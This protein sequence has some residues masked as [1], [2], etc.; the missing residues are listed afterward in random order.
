MIIIV[1][2]FEKRPFLSSR[3]SLHIQHVFRAVLRTFA[4][5]RDVT[6]RHFTIWLFYSFEP[7]AV[8]LK[9]ALPV[10]LLHDEICV[11]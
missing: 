2:I 3:E 9:F 10:L 11:P 7:A 5:G 8:F 4:K 6:W 1:L